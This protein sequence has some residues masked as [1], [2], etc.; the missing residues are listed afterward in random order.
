MATTDRTH[1]ASYTALM[2]AMTEIGM[3]HVA[4]IPPVTRN[5]TGILSIDIPF[6]GGLPEGRMI[7]VY[8]QKGAGKTT[9]WLMVARELMRR[10]QPIL[11]IDAERTVEREYC[12]LLGLDLDQ[13]DDEGNPLFTLVKPETAEQ[14]IDAITMTLEYG[15]HRLIVLDTLAQLV[16]ATEAAASVSKDQMGVAPR[17]YSRAMRVW[18]PFLDRSKATLV[19]LN[20]ERLDLGAYGAP[21]ISGGG[22]AISEHGPSI[23]CFM[24]RNDNRYADGRPAELV[25]RY[26][27]K[28]SKVFE[29]MPHSSQEDYHQI[30][31][32]CSPGRYELNWGYEL[33]VAALNY[34]LLEDKNGG[35]WSKNVAYFAGNP[36]GNGRKQV[37]EFFQTK[38]DLRDQIEAEI[39]KRSNP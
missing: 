19:I 27:I 1:P 6:H 35:T 33:L 24:G 36:L 12:E 10:G 22:K 5:P 25:F 13:T 31:I 9:M 17:L 37:E 32:A 26:D 38:S 34:G 4:H 29:F 23:I 16:P 28:K 2:K 3:E 39:I 30:H 18:T 15:R 8:G 7:L 21:R 11:W 20:Q 14:A